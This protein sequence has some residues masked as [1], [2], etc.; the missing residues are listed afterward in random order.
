M[1]ETERI[2]ALEGRVRALETELRELRSRL[3]QVLGGLSSPPAPSPQPGLS[4][5]AKISLFMDYFSGRSDVYALAWNNGEK[6]GWSPASFGRYNRKNPNLKPLTAEVIEQHLRRDNGTHVGLYPLCKDD[7]CR[8]LACDFDGDD[9]KQAATAYAAQ[10]LENGLHPLIEV[11]RSGDGAHVWLFFS[12]SVPASLARAVGIGL[13]TKASPANLF[14]S[15]DR[16]FPSQDTVPAKGR[17]FGNLIALPL[18]GQH[19]VE[20]TTV[21]VDEAFAPCPDQFQALAQ[22]LKSSAAELRRIYA[23]LSLD[24]DTSLPPAP[25]KAELKGLKQT[26]T[27]RITHD[28]RVHVDL[29]GVDSVTSN[30]LRHLGAIHNPQYYIKQA[31]RFST[32]GTPRVIVRF[33]EQDGTLTLDRGTLDD[34]ISILKTAGYTVSRRGGTPKPLPI[35]ASFSGTLHPRQTKAVEDVVR[36]AT[37]MLVAPPGAGKTVMACK[38]IAERNVPTAVVVPNTEL[39]T[40]WKR[41]L[42]TFLPDVAVGQHSGSKKRLSG[43]VDLVTAQSISRSDSRTDFLADYGQVIIDEC[44]RVGAAGLTSTL[45]DLNVRYVLGLTATPYRSDALDQLLPMICGP[46]RHRLQLERPGPKHYAVH[47]T[48]FVYEADHIF[49]PDLD[50]ALA[51]DKVRNQIIADVVESAASGQHNVLVLAKRREH[52]TALQELLRDSETPVF[53]LH[54]GQSAMR[55]QATREQ[56][57][58]SEHFILLA[59]SQVAGEGMDLPALDTLVLAAP[60]AFKGSIIQQVGRVTRDATGENEVGAVV[61]DF[62]DKQVPALVNAARKR[63][64]VLKKEG[65]RMAP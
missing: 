58:Q 46:I 40:Q 34:A 64:S 44:H 62:V 43:A 24:P 13:L 33:T 49:W 52:L 20:G 18:A 56:L 2:A 21:F 50:T 55:R 32:Y 1:A 57:N 5:T 47:T 37:G 65:F 45:A 9:F 3:E 38:I 15:F 41:A 22:T 16:F 30:A 39:I 10:C 59:M 54:G 60:V 31:Q 29:T 42:K 23:A 27:I 35:D 14:T 28:S 4:P 61:H 51:A 25:T 11:S 7:T 48:D 53:Q 36:H 26:G 63:Q 12:E 19:R 17:G 8:L 6:K